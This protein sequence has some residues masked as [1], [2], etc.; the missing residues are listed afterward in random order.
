MSIRAIAILIIALPMAAAARPIS[1]SGGFTVIAES[2]PLRDSLLA[3][4]SPSYKYSLGLQAVDDATL[5][6]DHLHLHLSYLL[7]RKNTARSQRNLYLSAGVSTRNADHHF[8]GLHGDWESRRWF[9]AFGHR[10][11]E[12]RDLDYEEHFLQ[13][14]VAPYLGDYGDWHTWL[15]LKSRKN[16]IDDEWDTY[17][18]LRLFKGVAMLEAGYSDD[19][20]WDV[21]M[22][23]RF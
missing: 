20:D 9:G 17:P 16:S 19:T 14:G 23:Y 7:N 13:V 8:Q 11:T 12:S 15:M 3:H 5:D 1:Y 6:K 18:T 22:I 2:G 4:Y 10:R 21:A